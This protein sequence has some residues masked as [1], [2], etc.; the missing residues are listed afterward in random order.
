MEKVLSDNLVEEILTMRLPS[1]KTFQKCSFIL[2][3]GKYLKQKEHYEA[4][5]FLVVEGLAP[6]IPDAED[7][8]DSLGYIRYSWIGYITLSSKAPTDEQY[9]SLENALIHIARDRY[10]ISVQAYG[11]SKHYVDYDLSDIPYIIDRIKL[12]YNIGKLLP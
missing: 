2:P 9:K 7:L 4:F 5:K 1:T 10:N 3:D 8:L 6:C 12:Y 11:D